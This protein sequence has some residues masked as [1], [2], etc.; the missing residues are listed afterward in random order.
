M[1]ASS[2]IRRHIDRNGGVPGDASNRPKR[3]IADP[4]H[5]F[6]EPKLDRLGRLTELTRDVLDHPRNRRRQRKS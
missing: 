4:R 2:L 3:A 1:S 5:A 6:I